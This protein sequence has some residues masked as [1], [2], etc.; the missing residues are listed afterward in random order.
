MRTTVPFGISTAPEEFHR[1]LSN[2]LE[3]LEGVS[4]VAADILIYGN[5]RAKYDENMRKFLKRANEC[6]LKLNKKKCRF[7]MT[8]LPYIG[9]ILNYRTSGTYLRYRIRRRCV[10]SETWKRPE[11]QTNATSPRTCQLHGKVHSELICRK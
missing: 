11:T 9:H 8:E 5:N 6:G 4:V 10:Q 2:T 7:H 1:R 3:G